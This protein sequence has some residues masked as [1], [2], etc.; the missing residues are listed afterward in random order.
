[1]RS[2]HG[3]FKRTFDCLH[4]GSLLSSCITLRRQCAGENLGSVSVLH[5]IIQDNKSNDTLIYTNLKKKSNAFQR[6]LIYSFTWLIRKQILIRPQQSIVS[7]SHEWQIF[8]TCMHIKSAV[9]YTSKPVYRLPFE[10]QDALSKELINQRLQLLV[11]V[12]NFIFYSSNSIK[13]LHDCQIVKYSSRQRK[14]CLLNLSPGQ[15]S[16]HR[17]N[18]FRHKKPVKLWIS[19]CLSVWAFIQCFSSF[20]DKSKCF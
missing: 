15:L 5:R 10:I 8:V 14:N 7:Y 9:D 4:S 6:V 16:L 18:S 3:M 19:A 1:M 11:V 13:L 12:Y 20:V 2:Q 17:S